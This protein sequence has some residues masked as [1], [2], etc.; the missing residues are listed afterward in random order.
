MKFQGVSTRERFYSDRL[1]SY[2]QVGDSRDL[3][4]QWLAKRTKG[5]GKGIVY[6]TDPAVERNV[7]ILNYVRIRPHL[8]EGTY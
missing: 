2:D 5:Q 3:V 7:M 1:E 4:Q 6:G 8:I